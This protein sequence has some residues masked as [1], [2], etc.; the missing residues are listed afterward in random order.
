MFNFALVGSFSNLCWII[1]VLFIARMISLNG[2][3]S[4]YNILLP[5]VDHEF[6]KLTNS[7]ININ[8]ETLQLGVILAR[9][10]HLP[11]TLLSKFTEYV[12]CGIWS[13][14]LIILSFQI[15]GRLKDTHP[16]FELILSSQTQFMNKSGNKNSHRDSHRIFIDPLFHC[17]LDRSLG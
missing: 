14:W 10:L 17:T 1:G 13:Y 5:T 9:D 12:N 8:F 16:W 2:I 4:W 3:S 6:K 15:N 11:G 7:N